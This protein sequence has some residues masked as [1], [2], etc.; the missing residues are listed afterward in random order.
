[1]AEPTSWVDDVEKLLLE[2]HDPSSEAEQWRKH[3]IYRVPA[4]IRNLNP[5]AYKPQMVSLGPFHHGDPDL[6]PMEKHKR[7]ALLCLLRRAAR[8][9]GDLVAAVADVEEE[10]RA[11]YVDLGDEWRCGGGRP[12]V[13]TMVVDGCFLLEVMRTAAAAGR[14]RAIVGYAA[15]DPVF[16]RHG[17]LYMAPYVQRDMLMVE[18]QLPLLLLERIVAAETGKT[19][20]GALIH[21]MVLS[22]LGAGNIDKHP[23]AN[24]GLHPLDIYRRSLLHSGCSSSSNPFR[25]IHLDDT[26]SEKPADVRSARK[27]YEA[28]IR[29]KHSGREDSLRDVHFHNGVLTMPQLFVDDSTEYKFLN[30]MAFEAL[31]AGAGSGS[32]DVTAYVFFLRSIVGSADDVR[33]LRGKGIV[34]SDWVDGDETVVRLLNGM[35][36]DVVCDETSALYCFVHG[37]VE[38]YC[39]SSAR[40]FLHVS[41]CYL[42]RT[43]FGNP[44]TFLSLAAGVLLLVTD[45][46]QTVYAVLSYEVQGKR[47]HHKWD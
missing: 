4:R 26:P 47:E 8:P 23:E 17:L 34:R 25:D 46:I 33:L 15:N 30:L 24:L 32:G 31:H 16:S 35:T 12:F 27:L 2:A 7:R 6:A 19:E 1:M 14:R 28:G 18:N 38:A 11:A 42:K 20:A 45:I 36:K 29:F 43:Y 22:F 40:V 3:S 5:G 13:E 44:W 37:E 9:L 10:L 39:R 41:W 21:W